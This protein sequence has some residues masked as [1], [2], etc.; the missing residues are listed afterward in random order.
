MKPLNLSPDGKGRAPLRLALT[1]GA[2]DAFG[3]LSMDLYM[4]ALPHLAQTLNTTDAMAQ[5]TMSVCMI[6]LGLGQLVVG[7]LSD[8]IGRRTPL[9][10]G[11]IGFAVFSAL[12]AVAPSIEILLVFRVLQGLCGSAGV[13]LAIAIARDVTSGRELIR[14]QSLLALV[15]ASAPIIAPVV[16]GQLVRFTDWRGI[17]WLLAALGVALFFLARTLPETLARARRRAGGGGELLTQIRGLFADKVFVMLLI[18][19]AFG[20]TAFFG[21]L[22]MC[23]FVLQ[24]EVGLNPQAFSAVFAVNALVYLG[25]AQASRMVAKR[26]VVFT[27][28][29]GQI[30]AASMTALFLIG[31]LT[32]WPWPLVLCFLALFMGFNGLGGPAQTT[33]AMDGHGERAGT[34]SAMMGVGAFMVGPIVAPLVASFGVSAQ[35]M[36]TLLVIGTAVTATLALTVTAPLIRRRGGL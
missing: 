24:G 3:P 15:G 1:L 17:F 29:T 26:G 25:G 2:L 35:S 13:V 34:A 32:H 23:S 19:G 22:S 12:C 9:L 8:R 11:V 14:M 31:V 36:G 28:L 10:I 16:G 21:Y 20:G 30:G 6:A 5:L 18:A 33:L 7:P 27:Y 4:P